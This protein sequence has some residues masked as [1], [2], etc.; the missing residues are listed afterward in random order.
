MAQRYKM[1]RTPIDINLKLKVRKASIERAIAKM[2][3]KKQV[4]IPMTKFLRFIANQETV[5][6][7]DFYDYVK[8]RRKVK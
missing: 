1:M 7:E 5:Y 4:R 3:G 8:H 2:T 6:P